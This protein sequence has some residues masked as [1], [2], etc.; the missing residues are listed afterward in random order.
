MVNKCA[1]KP[2][3]AADPRRDQRQV[4]QTGAL[5]IEA[6]RRY[7]PAQVVSVS[8]AKVIGNPRHISTS[9]VERQNLTLRM[10]QRRFTR[11]TSGFSK[12]LENHCAAASLYVAHY[13]VCRVHRALRV[14][15]AMQV[16]VTSHIWTIRELVEAS[17]DVVLAPKPQ[18]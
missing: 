10:T 1:R 4:C 13:N 16:G 12:K 18:G 8:T 7:S 6:K 9:Y 14:T 15:P 5:A 3:P 11:L 17:L 2:R